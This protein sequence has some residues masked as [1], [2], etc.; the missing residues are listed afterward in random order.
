M[1]IYKVFV[2]LVNSIFVTL[3]QEV[4]LLNSGSNYQKRSFKS[5]YFR[6]DFILLAWKIKYPSL[7]SVLLLDCYHYRPSLSTLTDEAALKADISNTLDF[8]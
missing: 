4:R 7:T 8:M 6:S 1:E 3:I 2:C 5:A